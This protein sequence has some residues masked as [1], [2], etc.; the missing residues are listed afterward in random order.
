MALT[1]AN[2]EL[3][4]IRRA[5]NLLT[6]AGLDGT[7]VDGTNVDLND[8]IGYGIRNVGGTVTDV[9]SVADADLAGISTDDYDALFD[10]AEYRLL[11]NIAGNLDSVD[12]RVGPQE[13][14]LSQLADF[15]DRRLNRL[16]AKLEDEYGLGY[17]TIEIGYTDQNFQQQLD[18]T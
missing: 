5:G 2:V 16:K 3:I 1:R 18:E 14:K 15:L 8:P 11:Q 4:L 7:T 10:Y 13:Q 6:A 9:T 17:A 12:I